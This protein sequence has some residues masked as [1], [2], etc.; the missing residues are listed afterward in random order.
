MTL[1]RPEIAGTP[2][3]P[4]NAPVPA[5]RSS[6]CTA[7]F[8]ERLNADH[9]TATATQCASLMTTP[10]TSS[11]TSCPPRTR[12][13]MPCVPSSTST[14][15]H[16]SLTFTRFKAMA[17]ENSWVPFGTYA[18]PTAFAS[19]SPPQTSSPRTPLPNARGAPSSQ[20]SCVC[21]KTATWHRRPRQELPLQLYHGGCSQRPRHTP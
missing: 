18:K 3:P 10:G 8:G 20:P 2:A 21:S 16:S 5:N 17:E 9:F 11:S 14:L 1:A 15:P 12:Q 7:T 19:S 4:P 6:W 13:Q